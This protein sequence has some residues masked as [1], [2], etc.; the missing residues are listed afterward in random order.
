MSGIFVFE[1]EWTGTR[2]ALADALR[3]SESVSGCIRVDSISAKDAA[4]QA[5]LEVEGDGYA[6]D[7]MA[8]IVDRIIGV[9]PLYARTPPPSPWPRRLAGVE[10]SEEDSNV[11]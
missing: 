9:T 7:G 4:Y 11:E 10:D 8:V 1:V 5:A 6:G 3:P 2:H